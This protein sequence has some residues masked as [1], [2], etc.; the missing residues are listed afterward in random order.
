[1][2]EESCVQSYSWVV[3]I[4]AWFRRRPGPMSCLEVDLRM[5]AGGARDE[6]TTSMPIWCR[7]RCRHQES[8]PWGKYD[9][10]HCFAS[11]RRYRSP[12]RLQH[13][14]WSRRGHIERRPG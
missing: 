12:H 8:L 4:D 2:E 3:R 14:S 1:M 5:L 6:P 9:T 11:D 10:T 7:H 13:C